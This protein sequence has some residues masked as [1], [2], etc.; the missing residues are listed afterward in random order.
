MCQAKGSTDPL[1]LYAYQQCKRSCV[2]GDTDNSLRVS[3]VSLSTLSPDFVRTQ[4]VDF[5]C[6]SFCCHIIARFELDV[7]GY[8]VAAF[9]DFRGDI[10]VAHAETR[11]GSK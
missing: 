2:S 9:V 10:L 1:S 6:M 4:L 3:A 11:R 5:D 7:F 8:S